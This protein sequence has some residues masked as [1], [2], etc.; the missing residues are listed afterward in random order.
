MSDAKHEVF[1]FHHSNCIVLAL[2]GVVLLA[3]DTCVWSKSLLMWLICQSL[4]VFFK[5]PCTLNQ[6]A[7][8]LQLSCKTK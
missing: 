7:V 1:V 8:T 5:D 6:I 2:P 4:L 3:G